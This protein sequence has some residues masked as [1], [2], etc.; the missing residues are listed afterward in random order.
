MSTMGAAAARWSCPAHLQLLT[1]LRRLPFSASFSTTVP[2]AAA[3]GFGWADALRVGGD[4]ARGDEA[5][6]SG[7][8][9]KVDIC[10]RGMVS[11]PFVLT[12]PRVYISYFVR[13]YG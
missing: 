13:I 12:C 2:R 9:Q 1:Q 4:S 3:T 10:N 7:Y 6:L 11:F 8:F 5:D